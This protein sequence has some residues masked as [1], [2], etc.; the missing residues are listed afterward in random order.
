MYVLILPA[1]GMISEIVAKYSQTVIFGRDSM[2]VAIV[3][4]A[5]LGMIV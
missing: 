1:F 3:S 5:F 2:L 4:I